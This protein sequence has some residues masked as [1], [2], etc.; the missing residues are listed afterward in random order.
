VRRSARRRHRRPMREGGV[1]AD[2]MGLLAVLLE[3]DLS[4][5]RLYGGPGAQLLTRI[6]GASA[7]TLGRSVYCSPSV[8]AALEAGRLS[9]L[10]LV[11][12]EAVHVIQVRRSGLVRFL[13][14]YVAEYLVLRLGGREH[15]SAY[16]HLSAEIEARRY[17]ERCIQALEQN[18]VLGVSL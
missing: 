11:A 9:A 4:A 7:L 8:W 15:R 12:H 3:E 6:A 16:L 5:V 18:A 13:G 17:A 14:R 10:E 2:W 1:L